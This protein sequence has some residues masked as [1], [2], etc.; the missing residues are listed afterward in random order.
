[1]NSDN[2]SLPEVYFTFV[3]TAVENSYSV[4]DIADTDP[5]R[6]VG[7]NHYCLSH[8][9]HPY[10]AF[11]LFKNVTQWKTDLSASG[12]KAH[13]RF[14]LGTLSIIRDELNRL[15]AERFSSTTG[16]PDRNGTIRSLSIAM[17]VLLSTA[18]RIRS[19]TAFLKDA[20]PSPPEEDDQNLLND[21]DAFVSTVDCTPFRKQFGLTVSQ[22]P[23]L[24]Q[25]RSR[26]TKSNTGRSNP[27]QS[28]SESHPRT[29]A[30]SFHDIEAIQDLALFH[31]L[32]V[33]QRWYSVV[34]QSQHFSRDDLGMLRLFFQDEIRKAK[35]TPPS[36]DDP[37]VLVDFDQ[38]FERLLKRAPVSFQGTLVSIGIKDE[39]DNV[40]FQIESPY[41]PE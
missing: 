25:L 40:T 27:C 7:A 30:F 19:V 4:L 37:T 20:L 18:D 24:A 14:A 2:E 39:G 15:E 38:Y 26:R 21:L 28:P 6:Y 5:L 9:I 17:A 23:P 13:E 1:M 29:V 10:Q 34:N 16:L 11:D 22:K 31:Y 36:T 8:T 32:Q 35:E 3:K 33:K 41:A 12:Y